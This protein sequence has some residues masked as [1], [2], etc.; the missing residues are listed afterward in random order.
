LPP[1]SSGKQH[2]HHP[3]FGEA[4]K[5]KLDKL[6]VECVVKFHEDCLNGPPIDAYVAFFLRHL[7]V[8]DIGS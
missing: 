4:L 7:G 3:R 8:K 5:E 1:N 6:G 2:I